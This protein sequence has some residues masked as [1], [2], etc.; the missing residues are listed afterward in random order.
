MNIPDVLVLVALILSVIEQVRAR[1]QS[2]LTWAVLLVCVALLWG[3][4]PL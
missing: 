1:G 2:L 3:Y 4:L